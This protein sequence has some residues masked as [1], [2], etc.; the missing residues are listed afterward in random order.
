MGHYN[1]Y[2]SYSSKDKVTMLKLLACIVLTAIFIPIGCLLTAMKRERRKREVQ[3]AVEEALRE[4]RQRGE[5]LPVVVV[6]P[7]AS[8]ASAAARGGGGSPFGGPEP[9]PPYRPPSS[10]HQQQQQKY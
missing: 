8:A 10:H 4:M 1:N 6:P 5:G 3:E 2:S 9:P 7:A